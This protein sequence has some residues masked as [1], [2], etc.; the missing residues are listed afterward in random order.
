MIRKA[1]GAIIYQQ[2]NYLLVYKSNINTTLG[3]QTISS[4]WD[5]VK[6]GVEARDADLESALLRELKEETGSTKYRI[7]KQF[8]RLL[9]FEFE[10]SI[11]EKIGF[12][13]QETTM[14][15]V[16][17]IGKISHLQPVDQEITRV[18]FVKKHTLVGTLSHDE[19][20]SYV[21]DLWSEL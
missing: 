5:F 16:E 8:E 4:A 17:F 19:T 14:F 9:S 15:L 21:S 18:R 11:Q 20:K 6:G 10:K 7:H 12:E 3:K 1:V 2:D 13:K